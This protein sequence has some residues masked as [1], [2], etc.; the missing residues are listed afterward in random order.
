MQTLRTL[1]QPW[2]SIS[3][4]AKAF[5]P[6]GASGERPLARLAA[7]RGRASVVRVADQQERIYHPPT[8]ESCAGA[9]SRSKLADVGGPA[10]VPSALTVVRRVSTH[11]YSCAGV[12][13]THHGIN[14]FIIPCTQS[15]QS[16]DVPPYRLH[17][18]R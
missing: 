14:H 9:A 2:R 1:R 13:A 3:E 17:P 18:A 11:S 16:H 6:G 7:R 12:E 10:H 15:C 5:D 4:A 8:G